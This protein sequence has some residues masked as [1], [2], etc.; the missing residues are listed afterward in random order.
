MKKIRY[1][2]ELTHA[3]QLTL[4]VMIVTLAFLTYVSYKIWLKR[5]K[6]IEATLR[7]MG[8]L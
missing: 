6:S 5:I 3:K 8:D 1:D 7:N 4:L 2:I